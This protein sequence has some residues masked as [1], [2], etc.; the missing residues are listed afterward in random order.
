MGKCGEGG[1]FQDGF[2]ERDGFW[3]FVRVECSNPGGDEPAFGFV[4]GEGALERFAEV[5]LERVGVD[6]FWVE[7]PLLIGLGFED[8][9]GVGEIGEEGGADE[10]LRFEA[11]IGEGGRDEIGGFVDEFGKAGAEG[12][13]FGSGGKVKISKTS[14]SL[15][16]YPTSSR[17]RSKKARGLVEMSGKLGIIVCQIP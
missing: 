4:L 8:A 2:G 7:V 17:M 9:V 12:G 6:G 11:G 10:E 14:P 1:G 3:G 15:T 5:G 16:T 13:G